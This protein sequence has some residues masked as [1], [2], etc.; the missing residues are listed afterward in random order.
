MSESYLMLDLDDMLRRA[1]AGDIDGTDVSALVADV[2]RKHRLLV[3]AETARHTAEKQVFDVSGELSTARRVIDA[4]Q[5]ML[6]AA[7]TP[8]HPEGGPLLGEGI[9]QL[10]AD[11]DAACL[12]WTART[13]DLEKE[14]RRLAE[15]RDVAWRAVAAQNAAEQQRDTANAA[16]VEAERQRDEMRGERDRA[17]TI[18]TALYAQNAVFYNTADPLT[19]R[20]ADAEAEAAREGVADPWAQ[21]A[22][23]RAALEAFVAGHPNT[24][25]ANT[26][27]AILARTDPEH[28]HFGDNGV[29]F[30]CGAA[31]DPAAG[32]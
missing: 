25:A 14:R 19:R 8:G 7:L 29:C 16:L 21:L 2:R 32:Q 13:A 18:A 30:E 20:R 1:E 17:R 28:E 10:V 31:T 4:A 5:S 15:A 26:I 23:L 6:G 9:R 24:L 12:G 27:S 3:E 22:Q 11:R